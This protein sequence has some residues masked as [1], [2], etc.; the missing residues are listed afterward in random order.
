MSNPEKLDLAEAADRITK[1]VRRDLTL[2]AAMRELIDWCAKRRPHRD[3]QPLRDLDFAAE[4]R[5]LRSWCHNVISEEPPDASITGIYFGLFN[6]TYSSVTVADLYVAGGVVSDGEWIPAVRNHWWPERRYARSQLLAQL[7]RVA[8]RSARG[9]GNDAEYPLAL[10][11][12][13]LA[14]KQLAPALPRKNVV[15]AAGFDSGDILTLGRLST[16]GLAMSPA[17]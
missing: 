1:L 16:K 7:Y 9:L 10:G 5:R 3:W 6:P 12:A 14:A 11:F 17:W 8:Y 4:L 13:V 2:G 15:I